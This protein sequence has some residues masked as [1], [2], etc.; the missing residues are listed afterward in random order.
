VGA[1]FA[2][3]DCT[4]DILETA[5]NGGSATELPFSYYTD[6]VFGHGLLQWDGGS[7][8]T[9]ASYY[10]Y[11]VGAC[12]PPLTSQLVAFRYV[13]ASTTPASAT[14]PLKQRAVFG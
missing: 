7:A 8:V 6:D 10:D 12:S 5:N 2:S 9:P 3:A 1:L 14:Y 13:S 11:P 4:G